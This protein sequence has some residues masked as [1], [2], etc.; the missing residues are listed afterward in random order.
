MNE[1]ES[2]HDFVIIETNLYYLFVFSCYL[3]SESDIQKSH[4]NGTAVKAMSTVAK[5]IKLATKSTCNL[6][7]LN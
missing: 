7:T 2:N 5:G 6:L 1:G 4:N 3:L